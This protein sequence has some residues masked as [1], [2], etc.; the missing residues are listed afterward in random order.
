MAK[1]W[2]IEPEEVARRLRQR[3]GN[4][5]RR[6][7]AGDGQWPVSISLGVP[8]EREAREHLSAVRA[9]QQRWHEWRGDGELVWVERRWSS[10]GTQQL[11]ER[12]ILHDPIQVAR[13]AG[14]AER[15]ERAEHRYRYMLGRWSRLKG[16]LAA[17]FDTLADYPEDDFHRLFSMLEWLQTH[18]ESGLYLR[19]LPVE[20][21]DTKWLSTRKS[22]VASLFQAIR[23]DAWRDNDF[24]ALTGIRREPVLMRMRLLDPDARS[25]TGGLKDITAPVEELAQLR[26]PIRAIYIVENLQT[27]LA[28]QELPGAALFTR[29]GYAVELFG[30]IAWLAPI[31]CFYWGDLDTHGF[32]ILNLLRH[33]LPQARSLL[34]D[35][36]TLLDHRSLWGREE[37]PAGNA[38]LP[39][40]TA[41]EQKLYAELRNHRFA[42]R[43][44]LEQERIPWDY[45]WSRIV[46]TA[47]SPRGTMEQHKLQKGT[48]RP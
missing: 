37:K 27:G 35:E 34:M 28:F 30:R 26:L 31:P 18:P 42:P 24:Y 39:L 36:P 22:L 12:L 1:S 6:W 16:S 29:L 41:A 38:V 20:G 23:E 5:H 13:W 40:L 21:V 7:L 17:H 4:Q 47:D 11:P 48:R 8:S 25:V 14:E 43:V 44:R 3:Y 9:W 46:A 15:W 45:A 33:Y 10:L 19:Q 2:L 32:A